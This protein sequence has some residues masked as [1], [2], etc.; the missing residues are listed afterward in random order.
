MGASRLLV[1][2]TVCTSAFCRASFEV[3]IASCVSPGAGEPR[4]R[5]TSAP[6]PPGGD[7]L[8]FDI[9]GQG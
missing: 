8:R 6:P 5:F 9:P 2:C 7:A 3:E 1:R 4:A